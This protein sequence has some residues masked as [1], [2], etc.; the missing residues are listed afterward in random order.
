MPD[1]D[2]LANAR[3]PLDALHADLSEK[4]APRCG[5]QELAMLQRLATHKTRGVA[6]IAAEIR[7]RLRLPERAAPRRRGRRLLDRTPLCHGGR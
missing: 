6:A 2:H 5:E 3:R 1:T 7:K 4:G